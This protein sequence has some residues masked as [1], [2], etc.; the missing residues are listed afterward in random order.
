MQKVE[1]IQFEFIDWLNNWKEIKIG[2]RTNCLKTSFLSNSRFWKNDM[3]ACGLND[4]TILL[5]STFLLGNSN[6]FSLETYIP[7]SFLILYNRHII[8][9]IITEYYM[10]IAT[11]INFKMIYWFLMDTSV[12]R[13]LWNENHNE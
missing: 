8:L 11:S 12:S 2:F 9:G 1:G 7:K 3:H 4:T 5:F 10:P 6:I 13:I